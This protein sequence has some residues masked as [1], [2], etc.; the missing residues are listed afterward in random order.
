MPGRSASRRRI[1]ARTSGRP[2]WSTPTA[3]QHEVA[4]LVADGST[5]TDAD[6]LARLSGTVKNHLTAIQRNLGARIASAL[7]VVPTTAVVP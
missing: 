2:A 6:R 3:R 1:S 7:A 4:E 5:N